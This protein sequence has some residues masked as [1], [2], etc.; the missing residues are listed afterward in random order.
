MATGKR[1]HNPVRWQVTVD[2]LVAVRS[3]SAAPAPNTVSV[4]FQESRKEFKG[5]VTLM[6]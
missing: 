1:Q 4:V 3:S 6:K 2:D 5:H